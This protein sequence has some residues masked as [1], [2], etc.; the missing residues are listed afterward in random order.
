KFSCIVEI[1]NCLNVSLRNRK[2]WYSNSDRKDVVTLEILP[3]HRECFY[4]SD[5]TS[6]EA[7]FSY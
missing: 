6:F 1:V 7:M 3:L 2:N 4:A 5:E